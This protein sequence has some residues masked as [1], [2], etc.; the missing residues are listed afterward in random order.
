[1]E[2]EDNEDDNHRGMSDRFHQALNISFQ[3]YSSPAMD[4]TGL[5]SS[6]QQTGEE[7]EDTEPLTVIYPWMKRIHNCQGM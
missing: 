3:S 1:M 5:S 4:L 2:R 6:Q 7:K